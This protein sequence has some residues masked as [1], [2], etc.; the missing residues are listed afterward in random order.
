MS[1]GFLWAIPFDEWIWTLLWHIVVRISRFFSVIFLVLWFPCN[2]KSNITHIILCCDC[3]L[4]PRWLL[5]GGWTVIQREGVWDRWWGWVVSTGTP[6]SFWIK[7]L[8]L[9][10][11]L[12]LMKAWDRITS[13]GYKHVGTKAW[14]LHILII[15]LKV[16]HSLYVKTFCIFWIL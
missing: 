15:D 13:A 7:E 4:R 6:S 1:C 11:H 14:D 3:I 8:F 16:V 9:Q 5:W 2:L 12:H 10:W